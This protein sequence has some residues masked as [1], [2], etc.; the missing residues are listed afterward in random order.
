MEVNTIDTHKKQVSGLPQVPLFS[1]FGFQVSLDPSWFLLALLITWTLASGLFPI[2]YPDL[3]TPVYWWMG[4]AGAIGIFFS[5]IFH[6][7]SH[8]MVARWFGIKISGIT[9]FVFGGVAK[10]EKEPPSPSSEF[11]M[12]AAGPLSSFLLAAIF[13]AIEDFAIASNWPTPV[14][15]V[16]FYLAYINTIL[17]IFNLVP[18]F[19][20]DGG[21]MFRAA[22]WAWKKD[23]RGA[24]KISSQIGRGFGLVLIILGV[25]SFIQG[26]FIGGMWWILIGMF[27]RGAASGSYKQ[28]LAKQVVSDE[29]I[30][31][32]MQHNP[33]TV[34]PSSSIADWIEDFVYEYHFKM[35]PVVEN[36]RLLG[37]ISTDSIKGL[38]RD[39]WQNTTVREL[40]VPVS[41]D[42]TIA[43]DTSTQELMSNFLL[44]RR[45]SRYMVVDKEQLVGMISLKDLLEVIAL[46]LEIEPSEK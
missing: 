26:N 2:D 4:V 11:L 15:G 32:F 22:L 3:E 8:S 21:R 20:L 43:S 35:F 31:S 42:N 45:G 29:P 30:S 13:S 27:L 25:L 17:A 38:S 5:I 46:K 34:P 33:V 40:M 18:A 44:N 6:E 41:K 28:L 14:V 12:A 10:L 7:F 9:L 24:T 39:D 23:L 36:S 1:L 16:L 19:P 37:C